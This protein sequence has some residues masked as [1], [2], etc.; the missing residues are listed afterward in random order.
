MNKGKEDA[1]ITL[2]KILGILVLFLYL[3][4]FVFSAVPNQFNKVM[5]GTE[6]Q[7]YEGS[8][9]TVNGTFYKCTS[10]EFNGTDII[11]IVRYVKEE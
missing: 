8:I 7:T 10:A 2:L 11:K 9:K 3:A 1:S 5:C 6:N 4:F